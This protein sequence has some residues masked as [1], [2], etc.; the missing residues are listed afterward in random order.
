ML[1]KVLK[2]CAPGSLVR[3]ERLL[4][5]Q[6]PYIHP[7]QHAGWLNQEQA[8]FYILMR[9]EER[10]SLARY[11]E[12]SVPFSLQTALAAVW[13]IAQALQQAHEQR[14]VHGHLK[15]E[16]CLV[17]APETIQVCDFAPTLLGRDIA[18]IQPLYIAPEQRH[19][20]LFPAS[21]QYAL[22]MLFCHLMSGKRAPFQQ[23][24]MPPTS[25]QP[26]PRF[27]VN[28]LTPLSV[29]VQQV[30]A[31]ALAP[32]PEERFPKMLDFAL[33]LQRASSQMRLSELPR[34]RSVPQSGGQSQSGVHQSGSHYLSPQPGPH[35][36]GSH[37]LEQPGHSSSRDMG[38]AP[39]FDPPT[40]MTAL[41]RL[42]GHTA[43]VTAVRWAGDN[44]HLASAGRDGNVRLWYVRQRVGTP[45]ATLKE[46]ASAVNALSWSA[47]GRFLA[48]AGA[49]ASMCIWN[50]SPVPK[51]EAR[52][53]TSW[54]G[55]DGPVTA[56]DWSREKLLASGGKD[57]MVRL[58]DWNGS[59]ITSWQLPGHG[60]VTALAWS[61]V[62]DVIAIGGSDGA[63]HLWNA[64]NGSSMGTYT[65]HRDEIRHLY[66]DSDGRLLIASAGK[67]DLNASLWDTQTGRKVGDLKGHKS[68]IISLFGPK[69][70]PWVG[71]LAADGMLRCW[72]TI[73]PFGAS[74]GQPISIG[75]APTA[76]DGASGQSVVVIGTA[77][78]LVQVMQWTS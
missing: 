73:A 20:Q 23:E 65:G 55:H 32:Q 69:G 30:F 78:M 75:L 38:A 76:A 31:Q 16:N 70:A 19:S 41:C 48:S 53:A 66:W 39:G 61:P 11:V 17:V 45:L 27:V 57:R 24:S 42:P 37:Y 62:Q 8:I 12:A 49:D 50:I 77:D 6:H 54:W 67:K 33:A 2:K 10:G 15:P 28:A 64:Q 13:Q 43:T 35:Q 4:S 36:S 3:L 1:I 44:N 21:D 74:L 68:E 51:F 5:L 29:R 47:D 63:I 40:K 7:I 26:Y 52:L 25:T 59:N 71:A 72:S 60:S 14:I 56:L 18:G 9:Y 58:W 46:N 34:P 22:A